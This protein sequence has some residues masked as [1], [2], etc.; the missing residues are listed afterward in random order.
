MTSRTARSEVRRRGERLGASKRE[1]SAVRVMWCKRCCE[2]DDRAEGHTVERIYCVRDNPCDQE[3]EGHTLVWGFAARYGS[4]LEPQLALD[5]PKLV[6]HLEVDS[7]S[8]TFSQSP[9]SGYAI[10]CSYCVSAFLLLLSRCYMH[11]LV[12][13]LRRTGSWNGRN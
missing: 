10:V 5:L 7:S 13:R 3:A 4:S 1:T 8:R 6:E 11:E 9:K 12:R 2:E